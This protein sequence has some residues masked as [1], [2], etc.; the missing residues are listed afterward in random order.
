MT[1]TALRIER[2]L[3]DVPVLPGNLNEP[4][5]NYITVQHQVPYLWKAFSLI[6]KLNGF[7]IYFFTS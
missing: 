7:F 5:I 4:I 6:H 1:M 3:N 2:D